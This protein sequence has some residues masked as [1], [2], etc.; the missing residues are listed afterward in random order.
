M[1][2]NRKSN[3]TLSGVPMLQRMR[4]WSDH[5]RM[6]W[7]GRGSYEGQVDWLREQ[8]R[9]YRD[10]Q[11]R[12]SNKDLE[13]ATMLEIGYGARP[14]RLMWLLSNGFDAWGIDLDHPVIKG[15]PSEFW[16]CYREN[17]L[18]RT[19]KSLIRH[20]GFDRAEWKQ[21][22]SSASGSGPF[23]PRV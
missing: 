10:I 17:G 12:Y 5:F 15:R 19:A 13:Q 2:V 8:V 7:R 9:R 3:S 23:L 20:Y 14:L 4:E 18:Q 16:R 22:F 1:S 21:I 11:G 6:R